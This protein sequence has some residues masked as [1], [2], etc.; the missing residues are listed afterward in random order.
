VTTPALERYFST[1][2]PERIWQVDEKQGAG[3]F[4]SLTSPRI[5]HMQRRKMSPT[6]FF[7]H[8]A[9]TDS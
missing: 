8:P 6:S 9:K 2:W 3:D 7:Q 1:E 5:N 4:S